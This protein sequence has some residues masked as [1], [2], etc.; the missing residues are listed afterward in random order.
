MQDKHPNG[1]QLHEG[2]RY[3]SPFT[4][5]LALG[6]YDGPT[7]GVLECRPDG[8]TYKFDL[9]DEV[10]QWPREEE[11]LRVFT[12]A[13]L[14]RGAIQRLAEAYARYLTPHWPV[15]IP[16]WKFPTASDQQAMDALTDEVLAQAGPTEWV[17][18]TTDLLGIILLARRATP[19]EVARV[20]DWPAFLG[21]GKDASVSE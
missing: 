15:W 21:L 11:D 4:K 13:P 16:A 1:E 2:S 8:Q 19:E 7:N 20:S 9:L 5:V 12:L 10:R 14:P 18:A 3:P 17:I 6:W